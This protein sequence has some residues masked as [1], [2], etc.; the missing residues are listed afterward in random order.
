MSEASLTRILADRITRA[1]AGILSPGLRTSRSPT[2]IFR[3]KISCF[4]PPRIIVVV[5]AES[6][7]NAFNFFVARACWKIAT[8]QFIPTIARVM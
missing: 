6:S 4:C 2:T 7:R 5:G 8:I 3:E 1:S